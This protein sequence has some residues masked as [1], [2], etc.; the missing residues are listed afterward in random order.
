MPPDPAPPQAPARLAGRWNIAALLAL[1]VL[2]NYFDRVNLTVSHNAI[3]AGFGISEFT[4]GLLAGAYNWTYAL[5][6]LPSGY[7]LDRFGVR[8]VGCV[9][10]FLWSIASFAAAATPSIGGFFGAR[11][12]LGVG[13]APTFPANAKAIGYWFPPERAQL[14]HQPVRFFGEILLG[15]RRPAHR[16][17]PAPHRMAPQLRRHRPP[18]PALLPALLLDLS[19]PAP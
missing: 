9:S 15:H 18:Q 11:F 7:L 6:Q 2:V 14:R 3:L 4:F 5:C 16:P 1:G 17:A 10:T 12:L 19:R 13:E 8:R